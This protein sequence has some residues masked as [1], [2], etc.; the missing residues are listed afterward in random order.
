MI[1]IFTI[2]IVKEVYHINDLII[3]MKESMTTPDNH[4][5]CISN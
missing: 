1:E 5:D 3:K 2:I 4:I